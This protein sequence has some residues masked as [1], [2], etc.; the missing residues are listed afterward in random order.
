LSNNVGTTDLVPALA[1]DARNV[2]WSAQSCPNAGCPWTILL[3]QPLGGGTN[4]G[5]SDPGQTVLDVAADGQNVY[6]LEAQIA[7]GQVA[8]DGT[9]AGAVMKAPSGGGASVMVA[10]ARFLY[11]GGTYRIAVDSNVIY[12]TEPCPANSVAYCGG[13][14]MK[15]P[16]AG[17]TPIQVTT[18]SGGSY[19]QIKVGP[20]GVYWAVPGMQ[21][22]MQPPP[23]TGLL[24]V[25]LGGGDPVMVIAPPVLAI[26]IDEA[27]IYWTTYSDMMSAPLPSGAPA[28][29]V[30]MTSSTSFDLAVD[31][32]SLYWMDTGRL[33]KLTPK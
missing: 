14:L 3:S 27:N 31:A 8:A 10:P 30:A 23:P 2:Y 13:A 6:W 12:W 16:V 9:V 15:V 19:S 18:W 21:S 4:T 24:R 26:T 22:L 28:T 20:G 11:S 1:V 25:P 29:S 33:M 17:G 7:P 32:T 5:L